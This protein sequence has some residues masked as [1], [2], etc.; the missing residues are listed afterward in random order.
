MQGR[1]G[2]LRHTTQGPEVLDGT[3]IEE[4]GPRRSQRPWSAADP[5]TQTDGRLARDA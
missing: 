3:L 1:D 5:P 2:Y 4:F